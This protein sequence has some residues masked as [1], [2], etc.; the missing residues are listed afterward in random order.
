[1][2]QSTFDF[3]RQRESSWL[4]DK[5]AL[6]N[7]SSVRVEVK[8][9]AYRSFRRQSRDTSCMTCESAGEEPRHG[10]VK[11]R[12]KRRGGYENLDS[13]HDASQCR[14]LQQA[15]SRGAKGI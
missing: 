11:P 9:R 12:T 7:R 8:K 13:N 14:G 3:F 4:G 5:I 1:M 10:G 2:L 15:L 6:S